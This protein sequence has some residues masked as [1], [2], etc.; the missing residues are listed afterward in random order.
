MTMW[1]SASD[2][3]RL[4]AAW[5]DAPTDNA[6]VCEMLLDVARV[7]VIAFAPKPDEEDP[8]TPWTLEEDE[9]WT[10]APRLVFAQLQQA[11]NLWMAAEA[12]ASGDIGAEGFSFVPRPLDKTIRQ[13]IRPTTGAPDAF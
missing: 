12:N 9:T 2:E 11:R 7:Q 1:F 5:E 10:P 8:T 3:D 13:M 6:E 4:L